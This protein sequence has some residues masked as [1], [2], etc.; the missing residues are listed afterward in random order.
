MEVLFLPQQMAHM[1][2]PN[3]ML[4][5]GFNQPGIPAA[6]LGNHDGQT[7]K[8][9]GNLSSSGKKLLQGEGYAHNVFN[10]VLKDFGR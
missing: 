7:V 8:K 10:N 2:N 9:E 1:Q 5:Q 3:V 4:Q 6:N